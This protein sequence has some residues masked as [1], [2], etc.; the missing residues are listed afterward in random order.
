MRWSETLI[1]G[2]L[3]GVLA[4]CMIPGCLTLTD[5]NGVQYT[6]LDPNVVGKVETGVQ[7]VAAVAPLFGAAGAAIAAAL[8]GALAVWRKVK[9]G[10]MVAKTQAQQYHAAASATVTAL[11][12]YKKVAPDQWNS[13]G[14]LIEDQLKKCGL[15]Q[16][17]VENVIR[18]LRGLSPKVSA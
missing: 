17:A 18:G 5:P 11:E 4:A 6:T 16:L 3:L 8:T 7:G 10:L 2:L 15:D 1:V 12:E 13:L 9:P 14:K